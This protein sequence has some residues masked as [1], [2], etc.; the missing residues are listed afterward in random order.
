MVESLTPERE[1]GGSIPTSAILSLSKDTFTTRKV[2]VI[3]RNQWLHPDM[4]E[5]LLTDFKHQHKQTNKIFLLLSVC[6][7]N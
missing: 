1:V 3:P 2:L 4:T 6:S 7:L 5:K